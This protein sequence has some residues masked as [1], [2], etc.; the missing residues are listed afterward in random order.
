M[1]I[2]DKRIEERKPETLNKDVLDYYVEAYV[3]Q[4]K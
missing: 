2:I 1:T 3:N 4:N